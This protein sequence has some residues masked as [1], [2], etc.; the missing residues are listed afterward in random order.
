MPKRLTTGEEDLLPENSSER[1]TDKA[2]TKESVSAALASPQ[3]EP[4]IPRRGDWT[5]PKANDPVVLD[6]DSDSRELFSSVGKEPGSK[7]VF[8]TLYSQYGRQ[9]ADLAAEPCPQP[10]STL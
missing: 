1:V 8:Q 5:P 7:D 4:A 3:L 2:G 6:S 10:R 9:D